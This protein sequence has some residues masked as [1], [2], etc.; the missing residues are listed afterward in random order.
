MKY[1]RVPW[2]KSI[3]TERVLPCINVFEMKIEIRNISAYSLINLKW[4]ITY[5]SLPMHLTVMFDFSKQINGLYD[6]SYSPGLLTLFQSVLRSI[7]HL[8]MISS[9]RVLVMALNTLAKVWLFCICVSFTCLVNT[10]Y[11]FLFPVVTFA[12]AFNS[13]S[14]RF[15]F[16]SIL[17][18]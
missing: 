9:I 18:V 17:V 14:I 7:Q 5:I 4:I 11:Q 6:I 15:P 2:K 16:V 10:S 3:C 12:S 8:S 13:T 1:Y